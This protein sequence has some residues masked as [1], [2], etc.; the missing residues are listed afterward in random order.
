MNDSTVREIAHIKY[1]APVDRLTLEEPIW[2]YDLAPR[3]KNAR[4]WVLVQRSD[5]YEQRVIEVIFELSDVLGEEDA[6]AT[7]KPVL[8]SILGQIAVELDVGIGEPQQTMFGYSND[9]GDWELKHSHSISWRAR[10]P[11]VVPDAEKREELATLLKQTPQSPQLLAAYR[12]ACSRHDPVAQFM[13][14]YNILLQ[15]CGD[16]Q[17][18]VDSFIRDALPGVEETVSPHRKGKTETVFTRLRNE[19]GHVRD[20]APSAQTVAEIEQHLPAIRD[21]VQAAIKNSY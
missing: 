4:V 8:D 18:R 14:L 10:P 11:D 7:T 3:V 21:L 15:N 5:S 17:G 6:Q 13:F 20:K 16:R 2:V 1:L 12:F 9:E 19:V